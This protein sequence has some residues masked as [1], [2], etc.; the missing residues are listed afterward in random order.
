MEPSD[1]SAQV[2]LRC[3]SLIASHASF[4]FALA[5]V[6]RF[7]ATAYLEPVPPQ[8]FIEL[9]H[10]LWQAYPAFPPFRGEFPT[11]IPHLTVAHGSAEAAELV[12]QELAVRL[13]SSGPVHA[14]CTSVALIENSA[15]H[16]RQ[17]HVF[18]LAPELGT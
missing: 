14:A 17:S 12:A 9:T 7:P 5:S 15:G 11:V 10:A 16:W 8:P 18:L 3:A 2:V 6:G 13:H 4:S 1:L